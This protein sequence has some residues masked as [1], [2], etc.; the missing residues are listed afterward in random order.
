ML[1]A[2]RGGVNAITDDE[3]F[4][5]GELEELLRS[6]EDAAELH[7]RYIQLEIWDEHEPE[8]GEHTKTGKNNN[9]GKRKR[10][11]EID[12]ARS[13][14]GQGEQASHGRKRGRVDLEALARFLRD[15][16]PL[17]SGEDDKD[18]DD[19]MFLGLERFDD[20]GEEED[21][22]EDDKDEY[23]D[24]EARRRIPVPATSIGHIDGEVIVDE[25]RP[26]SPEAGF[27]TH[28]GGY[29]EEYD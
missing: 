8:E 24:Y 13:D 4:V 16:V 2:Q 12:V 7:A 3:L 6:D 1:V 5:P 14:E 9:R 29:E 27:S 10:G 18:A 26:L 25:W 28:A 23:H 15:P 21:Y 20:E 17:A 11:S 22:V 19:A